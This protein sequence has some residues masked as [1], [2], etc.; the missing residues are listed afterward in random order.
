M[1]PRDELR[2]RLAHLPQKPGVYIM[3]DREGTVIY[4]GKSRSLKNRVRSYFV[5]RGHDSKTDRLVHSVT[6]FE[7]IVTT[8]ETEALILENNLIKKYKP[9]YNVRLKDSKTHPYL[10]ISLSEPYPRLAKVRRVKFNDGNRYFGPFP[11]ESGLRLIREILTKQFHLCDC[12]TPFKPGKPAKR[13][14]LNHHLGYCPGPCIEAITVDDYGK[15]VQRAIDFLS[16]RAALDVDGMKEQMQEHARNF[17]YEAAAELRNLIQALDG[18]FTRQKVEMTR[19]IDLDIWGTAFS[20]DLLVASIFFVRAGKLLGHR[21]IEAEKEPGSSEEQQ[22]GTLMSR[23]YEQNLIPQKIVVTVRPSP[24]EPLL[25]YLKTLSGREIRVGRPVRGEKRRLLNMADENA[26]EILRNLKSDDHERVAENVIDLER[27]LGLPRTPRRIECIDISHVQGADTVASLVCAINGA[28]R[29]GEYRLYHIKTVV[30]V[31][32]PAS[33]AEVTRRRFERLKR[34]GTSLPDLFVVDGGITQVRAAREVLR[35]LEIDVP[36]YG[37]AKREELLVHPDGS[38]IR[39]PVTSPA[40]RLLIKLRDEAH[41]FAHSFQR[42]THAKRVMR[43]S[44]LSLPGVGPK[45]LQTILTVYGSLERAA[46]ATFEEFQQRT[47]L[48]TRVAT[49]VWNSLRPVGSIRP[50]TEE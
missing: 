9:H 31:D 33:I 40:L 23:F 45:T 26:A 27:R 21:T 10:M 24:L 34:E 42:K 37:L 29:R 4:V 49:L 13:A 38:E 14:C 30:G 17:R 11:D 46:A 7:F 39:L 32:D 5:G 48:S 18:F 8:N 2:R 28:P 16:G 41:R 35:D 44:L 15:H 47:R 50:E 36:L 6:Q 12:T 25:S 22:V 1:I 3:Y 20:H 19:P 43:S